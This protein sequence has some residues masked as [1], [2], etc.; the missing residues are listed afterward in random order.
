[1]S[2]LA[3]SEQKTFELNQLSKIDLTVSLYPM[4]VAD[5]KASRFESSPY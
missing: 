3:P 4:R 5:N 1:M 2:A